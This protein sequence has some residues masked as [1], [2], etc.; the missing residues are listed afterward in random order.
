MGLLQLENNP[1]ILQ[2]SGG[3]DIKPCTFTI[4]ATDFVKGY[5]S[6]YHTKYNSP[7][8]TTFQ[9]T[10]GMAM[11]LNTIQNSV[12]SIWCTNTSYPFAKNNVNCTAVFD[13]SMLSIFPTTDVASCSVSDNS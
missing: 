6:Y 1:L 5:I 4:T 12:V 3:G 2:G 13:S 7:F 9:L 8:T 11:T 10:R